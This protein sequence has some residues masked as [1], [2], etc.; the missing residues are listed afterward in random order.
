MRYGEIP[1]Y[2]PDDVIEEFVFRT[3]GSRVPTSSTVDRLATVHA[4]SQE[5]ETFDRDDMDIDYEEYLSDLFSKYQ[6]DPANQRTLRRPSIGDTLR[7]KDQRI[8]FE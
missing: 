2:T 1:N 5:P 3:R 4:S 6:R 7:T 8:K